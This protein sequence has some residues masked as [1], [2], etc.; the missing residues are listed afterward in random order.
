MD[1]I[2]YIIAAVLVFNAMW[3]WSMHKSITQNR[4]HIVA[5]TG[6]I[7]SINDLIKINITPVFKVLAE[8]AEEGKKKKNEEEGV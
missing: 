7:V 4:N 2:F 1:P 3:M 8:A 6:T 5:L